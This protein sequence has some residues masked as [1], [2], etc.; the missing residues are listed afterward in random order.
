MKKIISIITLMVFMFSSISVFALDNGIVI[1]DYEYD[2]TNY[3]INLSGS[4]NGNMKEIPVTLQILSS[5]GDVL[6]AEQTI[7][8][9]NDNTYSFNSV[10]L[11]IDLTTGTYTVEVSEIFYG[12]KK[13]ETIDYSSI[14]DLYTAVNAVVSGLA[15]ATTETYAGI[16]DPYEEI[17]GMDKTVF[18]DLST[19]AR[20]YA[21]AHFKIPTYNVPQDLTTVANREALKQTAVLLRQTYLEGIAIGEYQDILT[22]TDATTWL[23][24]YYDTYNFGVDDLST[25]S[26]EVLLKAEYTNKKS[27]NV[28]LTRVIAAKGLTT[29]N[30]IRNSIHENALVSIIN[31]DYYTEAQ[32][33]VG[34]FPALF[35]IDT[36]DMAKLNPTEQ[37]EI[38]GQLRPFTYANCAAV[39]TKIDNLVDAKLQAKNNP[40]GEEGGDSGTGG[41]WGGSREDFSV[42]L[43]PPVVEPEVTPAPSFDD[44]SNV[45]WAEDEINYL[46][47]KEI[48]NGKAENKFFPQDNI[49]RAEFVKI[50]TL[51]MG[52]DIEDMVYEDI[53]FSDVGE[54]DWYY[55]Y[56]VYCKK[57]GIVNGDDNNQ[58]R[59]NEKITRQDIAVIIY[60]AVFQKQGGD[61]YSPEFEDN[62]TISSY[63]YDA[64]GCLNY[65]GIVKGNQDNCFEAKNNS[66]RAEAAVM[67]YRTFFE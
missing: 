9:S 33:I 47:E 11:P 27:N 17:L 44:L 54:T 38:Y 50:L 24:T 5:T 28:F 8:D 43:V 20:G 58:F 39:A 22:T 1:D 3:V 52:V 40:P 62:D 57:T 6:F 13:Q 10:Y 41:G 49:T 7:S 56:V 25:P 55:P 65:N 51:S 61:V 36:V 14:V 12:T 34:D 63:A 15:T 18:T 64:V 16:L 26:N 46:A 31:T 35:P 37:G 67:I 19:V 66:T 60:R 42:N 30:D 48:I 4:I 32:R 2:P 53:S 23:N 45:S 21:L 29:M 59:P